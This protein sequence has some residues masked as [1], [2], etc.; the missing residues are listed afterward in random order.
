[1]FSAEN[2]SSSTFQ[3]LMRIPE[4]SESN[5]GRAGDD[6]DFRVSALYSG[7]SFGWICSVK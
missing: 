6:M 5:R 1:M 4:R 7:A 3:A 2:K